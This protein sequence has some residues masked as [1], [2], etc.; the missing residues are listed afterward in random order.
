MQVRHD[1][2][3]LF[4]K[5]KR[6]T[7]ALRV[8]SSLHIPLWKRDL[9]HLTTVKWSKLSLNEITAITYLIFTSTQTWFAFNNDNEHNTTVVQLNFNAELFKMNMKKEWRAPL[10][11]PDQTRNQ[12][13]CIALDNTTTVTY[14]NAVR[15]WKAKACDTFTQGIWSWVVA[16]ENWLL[17][18]HIASVQNSTADNLSRQLNPDVE[19]KL[20]YIVFNNLTCCFGIPDIDLLASKLNHHRLSPSC[21]SDQMESFPTHCTA[22]SV[23]WVP[24]SSDWYAEY[25][26]WVL[27]TLGWCELFDS[28]G[29]LPL[30]HPRFS[31]R[32]W[33]LPVC[34]GTVGYWIEAWHMEGGREC[35]ESLGSSSWYVTVMHWRIM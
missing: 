6:I 7:S 2:L 1:C 34:Q 31:W 25:K 3:H 23:H 10:N 29:T 4:D 27:E 35:Q 24:N 15:G 33:G 22:M 12:H 19:W 11:K 21:S 8:S 5:N 20:S 13:I 30:E 9:Q 26:E 18:E 16:W 32:V 28:T 17:A 14:I